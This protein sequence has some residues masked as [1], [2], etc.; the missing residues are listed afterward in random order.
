MNFCRWSAGSPPL[1][2]PGAVALPSRESQRRALPLQGAVLSLPP[3]APHTRA[4]RSPALAPSTP[5]CSHRRGVMSIPLSCRF[6]CFLFVV[7]FF[8]FNQSSFSTAFSLHWGF[9]PAQHDQHLSIR[10]LVCRTAHRNIWFPP[11]LIFPIHLKPLRICLLS[12]G[13]VPSAS[14]PTSG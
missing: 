5:F 6:Q 2:L 7:F 13:S 12:L 3:S 9:I 11:L 14:E 10:S 4:L 8:F 1:T